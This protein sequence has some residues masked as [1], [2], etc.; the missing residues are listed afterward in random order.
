MHRQV[1]MKFRENWS[2]HRF[3]HYVLR[4][5]ITDHIWTKK[6][7]PQQWK[8]SIIACMY[9]TMTNWVVIIEVFLL[10]T[11]NNLD[12]IILS[13]L[14][15]NTRD[16]WYG[17][18]RRINYWS[19]IPHP[20]DTKGRH[21]STMGEHINYF[22]TSRNLWVDCYIGNAIKLCLEDALFKSR[23]GHMT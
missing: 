19:D 2:K 4:S 14:K 21:G 6:E 12:I 22:E 10:S 20:S 5:T 1:L 7:L 18:R 9:M 17:F 16:R 15:I 8:E 23:A 3:I 11:T 13:A